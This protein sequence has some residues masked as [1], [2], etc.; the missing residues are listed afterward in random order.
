MSIADFS[1]RAFGR[2][3]WRVALVL[4]LILLLAACGTTT[5]QPEQAAAVKR[6]G[7]VSLLPSEL[8]Y[9]KIGITVFNNERAT[10]PVGDVFNQ[11][12]RQGAEQALRQVGREVVQLDN[13]DVPVLA[14][15]I[16][17]AAII[18]DSEAERIED[19]LLALV[20]EHRLDA[21]VL[22]TE[23]ID[24][25]RGLNGIRMLFRSGFGSIR[26][27]VAQAGITT[28]L[29]D[30][31]IKKLAASYIGHGA[32]VFRPDGK[33]WTYRLDDDLDDATHAFVLERL[34]VF[35]AQG[36]ASDLSGM[37]F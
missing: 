12:A 16:R 31:R 9:E 7:V 26:F 20:Q 28:T 14:R 25:E 34:R 3:S 18:F 15:R 36:V 11:A 21:I 6:V 17:G 33:P 30:A 32:G 5:M 2:T 24:G 4:P 8:L 27:A 19:T 37:G 35:V 13:I 22:V 10:R 1:L 23:N 29:V